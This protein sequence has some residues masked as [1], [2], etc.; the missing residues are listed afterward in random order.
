MEVETI[1][2][3]NLF[4]SVKLKEQCD[5]YFNFFGLAKSSLIAKSYSDLIEK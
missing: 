4:T 2:H 1:D 3:D 5:F